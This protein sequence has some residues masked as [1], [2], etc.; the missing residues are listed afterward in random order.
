MK[1]K[2]LTSEQIG[3]VA[4]ALAQLIRAGIGTADGLHLLRQDEED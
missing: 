4:L 2:S 1:Q 3:T